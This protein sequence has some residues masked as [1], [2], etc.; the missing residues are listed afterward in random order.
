MFVRSGFAATVASDNLYS[1]TMRPRAVG[2]RGFEA[3]HA[4]HG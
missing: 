4:A 2:A 3:L 1:V